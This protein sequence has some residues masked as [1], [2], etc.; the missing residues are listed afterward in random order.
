M[1]TPVADF[2]NEYRLQSNRFHMP[3]HKGRLTA[4]D[5]TEVDGADVLYSPSGIILESE[6]NASEIF[7]SGR[8]IYSAEG[9]SL[10]IRATLYMLKMYAESLHKVPQIL[11]Y[12]NVHSS[13]ISACA[14]SDLSPTW[15]Y[16]DER[17]LISTHI[18][19]DELNALLRDLNPVACYVTSPDY[20]GNV[21]DVRAVSDLC[22]KHG[23][24]LIVDNAHGAYLKFL[25]KSRHPL[26]L[27]ADI[28]IDSAHKTLPCLTGAGYLH[29]SK[30][31]PSFFAENADD[32]MRLFA[33]T[34]PSYLILKSL[35]EFNAKAET[36]KN[37]I[38]STVNAV[39]NLK[40]RLSNVGYDL[41]GNEP[42]KITLATKSYGY[43]G[44]ETAKILLNNGVCAEFHDKDYLTLMF[45]PCNSNADIE[46]LGD[47]LTKI[48]RRAKILDLPPVFPKG[49][50]IMSVREAVFAPS[51]TV[52]AMNAKGRVLGN[53]TCSCPPAVPVAV[54]GELIT[55]DVINAL[56]YYGLD[57][58]KVVK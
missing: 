37:D 56:S 39:D 30:T 4:D 8:T 18:D 58:V 28:C 55:E 43:T 47:I 42:L 45:S 31:A 6:N 33:S 5:I 17:N 36:Y 23:A 14:L 51:E 15:L 40:T 24:L 21:A 13:F 49:T 7:G 29:I 12:R 57:Y 10:S 25:P 20:L 53:L 38:L 22:K 9:S 46:C 2:I 1:N 48:P 41:I 16:G 52:A 32:A 19:L 27:G 11:A 54:C 44:T 3:G 26:D 35:D 50:R 34:S